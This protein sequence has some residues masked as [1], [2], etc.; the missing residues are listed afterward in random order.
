MYDPRRSESGYRFT[1]HDL[2][3]R[4]AVFY[5]YAG[6]HF[7]FV[8]L[9]CC[10]AL[11]TTIFIVHLHTRANSVPLTPLSPKVGLPGSV[12]AAGFFKTQ[13]IRFF[14]AAVALSRFQV[15]G[16]FQ[17]MSGL[18]W[19]CTFSWLYRTHVLIQM[20][21]LGFRVYFLSFFWWKLWV[22]NQNVGR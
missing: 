2:Y 10:A 9:M 12:T 22:I 21:C 8:F 5:V 19:S 4:N 16:Q 7:Q 17:T 15:S 18:S 1:I 3:W 11:A 14:S 13:W 6:I 20:W